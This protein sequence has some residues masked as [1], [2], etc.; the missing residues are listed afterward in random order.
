MDFD[1]WSES[2]IDGRKADIFALFA[3]NVSLEMHTMVHSK[4]GVIWPTLEKQP[5]DHNELLSRCNFHIVYVG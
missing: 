2:I 1:M 3:I 4:N 5:M